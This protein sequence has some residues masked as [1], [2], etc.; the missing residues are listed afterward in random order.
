MVH[1]GLTANFKRHFLQCY[2]A[3]VHMKEPINLLGQSNITK[4]EMSK[5]VMQTAEPYCTWEATELMVKI[6]YSTYAKAYLEQVVANSI[7]MNSEGRNVLLSLIDHFEDL[8]GGTL[9]DWST[10]PANL[11]L[12][13]YSKP[14][15]IIY[16]PVPRINRGE[17]RKDLK[18]LLEIGV[19]TPVQQSQ[20]DTLVFIIPKKEGTVRF[21]TDYL[22]LNQQLVR[23]PYPSPRIGDTMQQL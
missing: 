10:D 7:Q 16:Y 15:N 11:E 1:L 20:Y 14:F 5:V 17:F 9:C 8:F 18:R 12:K 2:G 22:R 13:P 6:L 3:A 19:L 21:I 23:K 4:R